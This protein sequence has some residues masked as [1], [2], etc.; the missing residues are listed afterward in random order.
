MKELQLNRI[1]KAV[2]NEE[3]VTVVE[4][5][6][7]KYDH[8]FNDITSYEY[9]CYQKIGKA[10]E[11]YGTSIRNLKAY[12]KRI[13]GKVAAVHLK[14]RK[15]PESIS[16]YSTEA[17]TVFE[18]EDVLA[19]VEDTILE[20]ES[21]ETLIKKAALLAQRDSKKLA[22]L[23]AWSEGVTNDLELSRMLAHSIG[24]NIETH[25]TTIKRFRAKC[26]TKLAGIA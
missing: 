22:I 17:N 18:I 8:V 7:R 24:G 3:V 26:Q 11:N 14:R 21:H 4:M 19:N 1:A 9:E 20:T 25:R 16:L 10:I 13:C 15:I 6:S 2:G 12:A 23:K 5:M